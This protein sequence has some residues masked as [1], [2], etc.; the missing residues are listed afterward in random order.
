MN[1][2]P[3]YK[4]KFEQRHIA[5]NEAE[6]KAMLETVGAASL[7]EL[8][9]QTVPPQI[10]LK[11]PVGKEYTEVRNIVDEHKLHTI[12]ESGNCPNMGEC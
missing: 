12:C 6:T 4:E 1:L 9:E 2:N 7:D 8:A 11:Q 3:D 10:R 5:P